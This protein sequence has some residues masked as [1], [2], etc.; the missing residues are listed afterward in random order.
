MARKSQPRGLT[1]QE[2]FDQRLAGF[3]KTDA[4]H[5]TRL[6]YTAI[7]DATRATTSPKKDTLTKLQDWSLAAVE[8]HGVY[9]SAA[10]TLG[11]EEP[12]FAA[13]GTEG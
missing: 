12:H 4:Q 13:T 1:A 3:S 8:A 5:A 6:S 7:H 9:I 11:L 10:R 2:F